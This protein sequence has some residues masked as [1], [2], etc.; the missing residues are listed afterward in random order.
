MV[1]FKNRS[2]EKQ[3]A[4]NEEIIAE[5]KLKEEKKEKEED[6]NEDDNVD[7]MLAIKFGDEVN[8]IICKWFWWQIFKETFSSLCSMLNTIYY[9]ILNFSF[10]FFTQLWNHQYITDFGNI[11][12]IMSISEEAKFNSFQAESLKCLEIHYGFIVKP[13][14]VEKMPFINMLML[15]VVKKLHN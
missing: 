5:D 7:I 9:I 11:V 3:E 14:N 1:S 2:E 4:N 13:K 6:Q 12:P 10:G 15:I 8:K